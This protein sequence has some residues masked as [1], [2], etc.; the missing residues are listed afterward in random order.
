MASAAEACGLVASVSGQARERPKPIVKACDVPTLGAGSCHAQ[1][2]ALRA[3]EAC[4]GH[5]IRSARRVT[6]SRAT[7][8]ANRTRPAAAALATDRHHSSHDCHVGALRHAAF[9]E[10]PGS[11]AEC[12]LAVMGQRH[13]AML[14]AFAS[15]RQTACAAVG[16]EALHRWRANERRIEIAARDHTSI[17]TNPWSD[18]EWIAPCEVESMQGPA[19][20]P[21]SKGATPSFWNFFLDFI[22][23]GG[24][25]SP[26]SRPCSIHTLFVDRVDRRQCALARASRAS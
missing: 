26:E 19:T 1:K 5:A 11:R 8:R 9:L 25:G 14:R 16:A 17:T 24:K 13:P 15:L 21:A 12:A 3:A 4:V 6:A 20:P 22:H 10:D 7:K 2:P 18:H 23:V